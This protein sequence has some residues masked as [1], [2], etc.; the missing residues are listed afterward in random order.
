MN[1][2]RADLK[3]IAELI[4]AKSK[5]L[6]IGCGEGVLL[7]HLAAD[8]NVDARGIEINQQCAQKAM[9]AGL[10][11][12]QGDVNTD[13]S[14][15]PNK[16]YDFVVLSQALQALNDPSHVLDELLRIGERAIVSVPNFGHWRNRFHLAVKGR[17]PVTKQLTYEWYDTPNIHFCTIT[18]FVVL[19]ESKGIT[20]EHRIF[21]NE[22]G[23]KVHFQGKGFFANLVGQQGIFVLSRESAS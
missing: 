15:Y 17:M 13:L 6:D 21:M 18:D 16:A 2:L 10:S 9:S 4:P 23:T 8:K 5:V 20:I 14:Y 12:I 7:A 3:A 22:Q 1:D 19:C 11:V